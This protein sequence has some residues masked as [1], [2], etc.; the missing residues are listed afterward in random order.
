MVHTHV[1]D[2][3][4]GGNIFASRCIFNWPVSLDKFMH[5]QAAFVKVVT[6]DL[7]VGEIHASTIP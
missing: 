3:A 1:R 4:A 7:L 2:S 6:P 5:G